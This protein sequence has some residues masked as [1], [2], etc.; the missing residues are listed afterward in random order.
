MQNYAMNN[1]GIEIF[2]SEDG[3]TQVQVVLVNDTVWLNQYQLAEL[4]QTDRTSVNRHILNVYKSEE[5]NEDSTCAK[6]A[7]VQKGRKKMFQ[8]L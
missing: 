8:E 5:L 3:K 7:Q 6:I 1:S 2:K 4:F